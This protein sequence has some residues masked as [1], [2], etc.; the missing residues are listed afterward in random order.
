MKQNQP[1]SCLLLLNLVSGALTN[2]AL[3]T[4]VFIKNVDELFDSF[5]GKKNYPENGKKLRAAI[6]TNSPHLEDLFLIDVLVLFL[7]NVLF[8]LNC[9]CYFNFFSFL[10]NFHIQY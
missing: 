4:A 7:F 1:I 3:A 2:N 8:C 10:I 5:N 9:G 6:S